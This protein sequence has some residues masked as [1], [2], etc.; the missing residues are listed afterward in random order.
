M[1]AAPAKKKGRPPATVR[2]RRLLTM[3]PWLASRP[4][5]ATFDEIAERFG[6]TP[7]QVEEDL[8]RATMIG[9]PPYGPGDL[10]EIAID[11]D[12]AQMVF[13]RVF[14]QAPR[15]TTAEGFAVLAA[16]KALLEVPGADQEGHLCA[17]LEKLEAVLGDPDRL[18]VDISRPSHL[19]AVQSAAEEGRRLWIRYFSAWRDEESTREIEP[20]VVYNREGR[21]YVDGLDSA[22]GEV[23]RFRVDRIREVRE[24]GATFE[25]PGTSPPEDVFEPPVDATP[26]T[27]LVPAGARWV[28]ETYPVDCAEAGDGRFR[29]TFNVV[30][31]AW[32]ERLLL[33]LG[34]E[35]E[36]VDPPALRDT[37]RDAAR[38]VLAAYEAR[39]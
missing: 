15:L 21:W 6:I 17:A 12:R 11:G 13:G 27:V 25:P 37:G 9:L 1:T 20:H 3:L 38:R 18:A 28:I 4:D 8:M 34:P 23:R 33:R 10:V 2:L 22:S 39:A 26:V 5:G 30:G 16:G 35:A 36:I 32:L 19:P 24:T 14:E 29:V 31:T 7:K